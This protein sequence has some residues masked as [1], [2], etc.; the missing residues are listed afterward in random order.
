MACLLQMRD[1]VTKLVR[2]PVAKSIKAAV[3]K[4]Y[5]HA[6][7]SLVEGAVLLEALRACKALVL[8]SHML[9]AAFLVI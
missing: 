6:D 8:S 7:E 3:Q 4:H 9:T 5:E 2:A 1:S